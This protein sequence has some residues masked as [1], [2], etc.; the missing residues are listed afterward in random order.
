VSAATG[1]PR[2]ESCQPWYNLYDR[3]DFEQSLAALCRQEDVGVI[4]YFSLA[5]GFLTGKYRSEKD[6]AGSARGYRVK[7]M[8][9]DRGLGILA[10]LDAVARDTGGTPAQVSLAWLLARGVT[11]PIAS[12][13]SAAQLHELLGALDLKLDAA[14]LERLDAASAG[15]VP[16]KPRAPPPRRS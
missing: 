14:S 10:A 4:S 2:Y 11:A 13:R 16:D 12:A 6:L 3:A 15:D 9:N 8:L 1:L 5:S 7:D